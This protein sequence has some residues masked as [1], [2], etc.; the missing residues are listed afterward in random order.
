[1]ARHNVWIP[2]ELWE[3]AE[4][5]ARRLSYEMGDQISVSELIRRGLEHQLEIVDGELASGASTSDIASLW[6]A[7]MR[8]E[9]EPSVLPLLRSRPESREPDRAAL[10]RLLRAALD[11]VE[12]RPPG[13]RKS[14]FYSGKRPGSGPWLDPGSPPEARGGPDGPDPPEPPDEP[15]PWYS[16]LKPRPP[17]LSGQEKKDIPAN[18]G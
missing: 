1:V 7:L 2:D 4:E 12:G 17:H 6:Q 3:R 8:R 9:E 16:P 18:D 11:E 5:L 14:L 13:S 10:A 15:F